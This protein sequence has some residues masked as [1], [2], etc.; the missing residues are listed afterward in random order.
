MTKT[1]INVSNIELY[2]V[3]AEF[4]TYTKQFIDGGYVAIDWLP[5][6]DL[7]HITTREELYPLYKKEYPNDKSN[8][9]IGQ[10]VGQ[11]GRFL[12]EIK[13]GDYVI[14]PAQNTE[15]IYYGIVEPDAYF[16]AE[17]PDDFPYLHRKK[18]KWNKL[19]IQRSQFSVPF[20][21]TI[22]SSLT[23]FI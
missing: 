3:R 8:V 4:G 19:P 5:N 6:D 10:Q 23:V 2:C 15:F 22:R 21:N 7:S 14:T 11:I 18:V 20:Q 1:N 17:N 13:E 9:V 12:L 16:F